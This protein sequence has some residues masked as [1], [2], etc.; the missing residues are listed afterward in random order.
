MLSFNIK[1][2]CNI[3]FNNKKNYFNGMGREIKHK[4]P[5]LKNISSTR[6]QSKKITKTA[7]L[8]CNYVITIPVFLCRLKRSMS[9]FV[10]KY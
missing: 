8:S 1:G 9:Y 2:L 3:N 10:T 4:D 5:G 7:W 6:H